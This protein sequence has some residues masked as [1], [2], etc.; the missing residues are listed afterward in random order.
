MVVDQ[1]PNE[2]VQVKQTRPD[3]RLYLT[4]YCSFRN[5]FLVD[6]VDL[7]WVDVFVHGTNL[8]HPQTCLC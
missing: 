3:T 4:C 5:L 1:E 7:A 6:L 8:M 2:V